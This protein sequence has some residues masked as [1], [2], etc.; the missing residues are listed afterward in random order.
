MARG[1]QTPG[2]DVL[3]TLEVASASPQASA[4]TIA[5]VVGVE[6][7]TVLD[8]FAKYQPV[9]DELRVMK[10]DWIAGMWQS[11][12]GGALGKLHELAYGQGS[13]A[14]QA[15]DWSVVAGV[16]TDKLLILNG[17]PTQII[18]AMHEVRISL[19]DLASRLATVGKQIA[20]PQPVVID[21]P[22]SE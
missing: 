6:H 19:P 10:R 11:A 14:K 20:G 1:R 22:K 13:D 4:A 2:S 9:A 12:L 15:R 18:G 3:A 7:R 16:A 5:R 8:L 21:V 17:M